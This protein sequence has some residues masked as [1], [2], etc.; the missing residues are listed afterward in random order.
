MNVA[1]HAFCYIGNLG[2]FFLPSLAKAYTLDSRFSPVLLMSVKKNMWNC[3]GKEFGGK[4]KNLEK[5]VHLLSFSG[6]VNILAKS[7]AKTRRMV[8]SL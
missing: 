3:N 4:K 8:I 5:G 1:H 2:L 7:Q 6:K